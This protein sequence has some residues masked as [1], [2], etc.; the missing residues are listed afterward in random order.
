MHVVSPTVNDKEADTQHS[1]VLTIDNSKVRLNEEAKTI[2][3]PPSS[4]AQ[5]YH[6]RLKESLDPGTLRASSFHNS[7]AISKTDVFLD[8]VDQEDESNSVA[9]PKSIKAIFPQKPKR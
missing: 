7:W 2:L 8:K 3:S 4:L 5:K 9:S 1:L 6:S